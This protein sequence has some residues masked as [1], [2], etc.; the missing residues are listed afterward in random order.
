MTE[1]RT[2]WCRACPSRCGVIAEI[3]GDRIVGVRGDADNPLSL[4]QWCAA[5]EDTIAAL[6]RDR[7]TTPLR[8]DGD[9]WVPAS[10]DEAIRA[11]G[12]TLGRIRADGGP[13]AVAVYA[14]A[15]AGTVPQDAARIAAFA[16]TMGTPNLFTDGAT[17]SSSFL[18]ATEQVIGRP[19]TLQADI[20]RANFAVTFDAEPSTADWGP[21]QG[22]MV[23]G[24]WQER[25]RKAKKARSVVAD[26]RKT[27]AAAAAE[28]WLPIR[29]GTE[30][31]MVI[32]MLAATVQGKWYDAQYVR[33]YV[34]GFDA[35]ADA[36][37]GW[38]VER[39][40]RICGVEAGALSGAALK[41]ARAPMAAML[42]GHGLLSNGQSTLGA[43][44]V[45]ALHAVTANLLRPGGLYDSAGL[46]DLEAA[47][48]LVPTRDAPRSRV[49]DAP[50]IRLQLPGT[51]LA[52]EVLTEGDG[53]VQALLSVG[54]PTLEGPAGWAGAALA[55]LKLFVQL[56]PRLTP[57]S[58]YAHWVLPTPDV[59]EQPHSMLLDTARLPLRWM[60]VGAPLTSPPAEARP[61]AS[62]LGD[63]LRATPTPWR[64]GVWGG[65][66]LA[67]GRLLGTGDLAAWERRAADVLSDVDVAALARDGAVLRGDVD[68]ARWRPSTG[69]L[70][71]G[72]EPF[73]RDLAAMPDPMIPPDHLW[74]G[75]RPAT[76]PSETPMIEVH[77]DVLRER[78]IE[79]GR[80][81]RLRGS[82][83]ELRVRAV[84][85][86]QLRPDTL[87]F[88]GGWGRGPRQR[89]SFLSAIDRDPYSGAPRI[90]GAPVALAP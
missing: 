35:L 58:R 3:D 56:T 48:S 80:F 70:E 57:A 51:L 37:S 50:A 11:I 73:L 41:F 14:D 46:V 67:L 86:P 38:S 69:G 89:L 28:V 27:A 59:W 6:S 39:A 53:A 9:R 31:A 20:G 17:W 22:G 61:A 44:A 25:M 63:L 62:I 81:A 13:R 49:A 66:V 78:K 65:A 47:L 18:Y 72:I 10:W 23:V 1:Q 74:L 16:V 45:L 29:P 36:L 60:A 79:E 75:C 82:G 5:G 42:P 84:A 40:A 64:G 55:R 8:R 85:D 77:P 24:R 7:V 21:L 54:D 71:L 2:S 33:D 26:A 88:V 32:G 30:T 83:G 19:Y 52:D 15:S 90:A 87:I 68:R 76:E 34:R 43:F 12:P 4:G